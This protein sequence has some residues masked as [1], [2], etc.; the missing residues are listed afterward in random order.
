[1]NLKLLSSMKKPFLHLG[2][3]IA[4]SLF[5][6]LPTLAKAGECVPS[7]KIDAAVICDAIDPHDQT[8]CTAEQ[9]CL[10]QI[11]GSIMGGTV[12]CYPFAQPIVMQVKCIVQVLADTEKTPEENCLDLKTGKDHL[13][14]CEWK[15]TPTPETGG[16]SSAV[17]TTPPTGPTKPPEVFKPTLVELVNPIGGSDSNKKGQTN[18]YQIVGGIITKMLGILG[19]LALLVFVF[20]GFMWV[21]AAGNA[22]K[23]KQ[24]TEAMVW[25]AIGICIIFSSYAI[26]KLVFT[27][28]GAVGFNAT[29]FEQK[30][31]QV[32]CLD[33]KTNLCMAM[34]KSVCTNKPFD[35]QATCESTAAQDAKDLQQGQDNPTVQ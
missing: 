12:S 18:L 21:T 8:A 13:S 35:D 23:V 28:I 30:Q 32:W 15:D 29:S 14:V 16:S 22:D 10:S 31:G 19:S 7:K 1:M 9:V 20:G 2:V 24:G 17:E 25:A 5:C 34:E 27:G 3:Y 11:K 6:F 33:I 26:L 4:F